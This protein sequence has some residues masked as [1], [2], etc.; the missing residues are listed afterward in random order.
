MWTVGYITEDEYKQAKAMP[1]LILDEPN[2][3]HDEVIKY[4]EI[5]TYVLNEVAEKMD[6]DFEGAKYSGLEIYTSFDPKA[7]D[8]VR[9]ALQNDSLYPPSASDGSKSQTAVS[10]VNPKN[11]EILALSGG[12]EAPKFTELN[13][14]Y[15]SK[16]QPGS[17]F[18]PI[19]DYAPAIE[20]GKFHPWSVLIDQPG[21]TFRGGY[22]P[23]NYSGKGNGKMTMVDALKVSQ[24]IPAVYLLDNTGIDY[25]IRFAE[26]LGI[27]FTDADR[28]LPIA[29]GGLS[30]GVST[31][32]MADAYQGFANGGYRIPAHM[33]K[34]MVNTDGEVVFEAP[35]EL[36]DSHRVMQPQT[37]EYMRYMLQNAVQSGTGTS[38]QVSGELVGGKTGT[39]DKNKDL[40]FTG[41]TS[42]FTMSVWLGYDNPQTINGG[43]YMSAKIFSDIG[44]KLAETYPDGDV[45]FTTPKKITPKVESLEL[46]GSYNEKGKVISLSWEDIEDSTYDLYRNGEAIAKDL[47]KTSYKDTKLEEGK[48]YEYRVVGHNNYT[49][50]E[51]HKSNSLTFE[52]EKTKKAPSSAKI[53]A[54]NI[55][56]NRKTPATLAA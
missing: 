3:A 39:T 13:R 38:A 23:K 16:R 28:Y 6:T 47:K 48:T 17:S 26:R 25:A 19:I 32:Q 36:T 27:H 29:L 50:F 52:I 44:K 43:S 31:L 49:N 51:T 20:S 37:A 8:A 14:A 34:R 7:Y 46:K 55:T 45:K 53:N 24:N 30:E 5:V 10:I 41:F 9:N 33:V 1:F 18:K 35:S 54:S 42:E 4:G 12:R 21:T 11:G 56:T 15:Q 40:W 22:A 2:I